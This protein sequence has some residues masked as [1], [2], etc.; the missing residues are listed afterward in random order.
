MKWLKKGYRTVAINVAMAVPVI[1]DVSWAVV[2]TVEFGTVIPPAW[3]PYY[4]LM[5]VAGNIFL[6]QITTTPIGRSE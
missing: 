2:Q 4:S 6:R 1:L 5:I 3:I